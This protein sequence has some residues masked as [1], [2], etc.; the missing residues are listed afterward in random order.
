MVGTAALVCSV[1][2]SEPLLELPEGQLA[3]HARGLH[4]GLAVREHEP[5]ALPLRAKP[6]LSER[7]FELVPRLRG[8]Q[9]RR[10]YL[11]PVEQ[12]LSSCPSGLPVFAGRDVR[13][14]RVPVVFV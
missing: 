8:S 1:I 2:G 5:L 10:V 3:V 14:L 12:R 6:V 11:D 7:A 9:L 4:L 13:L